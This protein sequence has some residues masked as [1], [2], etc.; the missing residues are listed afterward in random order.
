MILTIYFS[1]MVA[2]YVVTK[3]FQSD[4]NASALIERLIYSL[5]SWLGLVSY[6]IYLLH[7]LAK[8]KLPKYN[9]FC[10]K[11]TPKWL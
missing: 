4:N 6:G 1:G 7:E 3:V 11:T 5:M 10:K 8:D 9:K 2:M